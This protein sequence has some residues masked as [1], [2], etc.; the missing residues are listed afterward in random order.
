M[1]AS[2][3]ASCGPVPYSSK[4]AILSMGQGPI[5]LPPEFGEDEVVHLD[6]QRVLLLLPRARC[7]VNDD[8]QAPAAAHWARRTRGACCGDKPLA[9]TGASY[10]MYGSALTP[11]RHLRLMTVELFAPTTLMLLQLAVK[12]RRHSVRK[13]ASHICS[14]WPGLRTQRRGAQVGDELGG[15]A[16]CTG[17]TGGYASSD[18]KMQ[19]SQSR[20]DDLTFW[21]ADLEHV[22]HFS[23]FLHRPCGQWY[24]GTKLPFELVVRSSDVVGHCKWHWCLPAATRNATGAAR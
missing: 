16:T 23:G 24:T 5:A 19:P 3:S 1:P 13:P 2:A 22:P 10:S 11:V 12:C 7:T 4:W 14:P 8:R 18:M 9:T 6:L 20:A 17:M 15:G 21:L